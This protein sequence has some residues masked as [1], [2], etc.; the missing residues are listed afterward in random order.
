MDNVAIVLAVITVVIGL[1]LIGAWIGMLVFGA[2][3]IAWHHGAGPSF[4][5]TLF[6]L[7]SIGIIGGFFNGSRYSGAAK[8]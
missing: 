6:G 7:W 1:I 4:S 3:S 2:A 8:K 5:Q